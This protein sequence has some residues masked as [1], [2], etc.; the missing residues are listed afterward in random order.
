[1]ATAHRACRCLRHRSGGS[2]QRAL[3]GLCGDDRSPKP[4][5]PYGTGALV[6]AKGIEQLPV[7][8]VTWY[9]AKA[10]CAW[11]KK[12]LPTEAEWEKAA[13]GTDGRTYP[14]GN[15]EAT[16]TRANYDRGGSTR[17]RSMRWGRC[18]EAT[19]PMASGHVRQTLVSGFGTGTTLTTRTRR[20]RIR[21]VRTRASCGSFEEDPG[22]VRW[23]TLRRPRVV[24]ADLHCRP[25][26][27]DSAVCVVWRDRTLPLTNRRPSES[28]WAAQAD[29]N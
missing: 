4:P 22:T 1:M 24:G 23:L 8:Q 6:S 19:H 11:A 14:W 7:V 15:D 21:K 2:D 3:P 29:R 26:G 10:Y 16:S 12:R 28:R 13:R 5:N 9:D 18:Q 25:M 27:P 17:R 20:R